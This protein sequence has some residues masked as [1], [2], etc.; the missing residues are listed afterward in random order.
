VRQREFLI[1]IPATQ[2]YQLFSKV[3]DA[4]AIVNP[5][6][7]VRW[8]RA[9]FR[10]YWRWKSRPHGGRPTV[11]L[12]IR[13]LIRCG[14]PRVHSELLKLGIHT[15]QVGVEQRRLEGKGTVVAGNP[16]IKKAYLGL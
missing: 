10:S 4:L 1:S 16:E 8:H 5:A 12:K 15:G 14:G 6:P 3:C 13:G 11:P 7:I 9:G 2:I